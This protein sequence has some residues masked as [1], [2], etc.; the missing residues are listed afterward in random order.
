[1]A[2]DSHANGDEAVAENA[3][4]NRELPSELEKQIIRQVEVTD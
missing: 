4:K 3:E 2:D 1:M